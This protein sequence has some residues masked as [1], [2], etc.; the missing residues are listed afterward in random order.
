WRCLPFAQG[1][2]GPVTLH[3]CKR[4]PAAE[5]KTCRL[6]EAARTNY[7]RRG[8]MAVNTPDEAACTAKSPI[9]RTIPGCCAFPTEHVEARCRTLAPESRHIVAFLPSGTTS[10]A[11]TLIPST[12]CGV[13][14]RSARQRV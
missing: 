3:R 1:F 12:L 9:S 4:W 14:V 13:H 5:N 6:L 7:L 8:V 10:R 2:I 11:A